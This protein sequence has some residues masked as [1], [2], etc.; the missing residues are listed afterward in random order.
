MGKLIRALQKSQEEELQRRQTQ[1]GL[2]LGPDGQPLPADQQ[3]AGAGQQLIDPSKLPF[4]KV[5]YDYNSETANPAQGIDLSVKKGDLVAVLSKSDPIGN[6]SDWWLCRTRDKRE[7]YLPGVYLEEIQRKP[8]EIGNGSASASASAAGSGVNS[9]RLQTMT[10]SRENSLKGQFAAASAVALKKDGI[11][12]N[13]NKKA[14]VLPEGKPG[15]ISVE[16][17]QKSQFYS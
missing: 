10:D 16:S 12:N 7:G 15:D 17:F 5:L 9:P 2:L 6:P 11:N 3:P 14:P 13:S 4:C 8:R 1:Q